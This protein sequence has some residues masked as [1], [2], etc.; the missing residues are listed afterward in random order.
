MVIP[1]LL[2]MVK[3]FTSKEI[4]YNFSTKKGIIKEVRTQ[5]GDS[6]ILGEKV[7]KNQDDVVFTS[8]GRYTTCDADT[9]H[10]SIKA[11]R[12]KTIPNKKIITGPALLEFGGVPTPLAIPFGFFQIRK[13]KAQ[14]S[15]FHFM[16]N[17]PI[18][19]S[20]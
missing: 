18:R 5:E 8:R 9:P 6:Y 15:F 3:A 1:F 19:V 20:F 17:L 16:E 13:N 2:K 14:V 11:K 4:T 7:K 10:F 12:I